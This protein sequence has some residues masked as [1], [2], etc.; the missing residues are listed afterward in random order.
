MAQLRQEEE[1]HNDLRVTQLPEEERLDIL[2]DLQQKWNDVNAKY[3]LLTHQVT[4]DEPR[5][6][7]K[8]ALERELDMLSTDIRLLSQKNVFVREQT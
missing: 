6:R 1:E 3:Q 7:L 5:K 8:E 4:M 2:N